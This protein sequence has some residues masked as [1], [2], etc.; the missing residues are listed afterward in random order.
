M[1]GLVSFKRRAANYRENDG[2][3]KSEQLQLLFA[4]GSTFE[5]TVFE[6]CRIS[7]ATL[8]NAT[9]KDV[10]FRR[11]E[12]TGASFRAAAL[13]LCTFDFCTMVG[14]SFEAARL[15]GVGFNFCELEG[16]TFLGSTL[17]APVSFV[18]SGLMNA[19]LRFYESEAGQPNFVRADLRGVTFSVNCE[20]WNG[21]FDDKATAD[22]GR[23]FARASKDPALIAM[24][25]ERWGAAEYDKVD[26]YMR[27]G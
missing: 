10:T 23:V 14:A 3:Y 12:L 11:C 22:F 13:D 27:R 6:D 16:S 18:E 24:V 9:L 2:L 25:K 26:R 17:Q 15:R 1:P 19:D 7:L 8:T 21:T 5:G 4:P 20:F